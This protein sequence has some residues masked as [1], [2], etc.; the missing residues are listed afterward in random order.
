MKK[1]LSLTLSLVLTLSALLCGNAQADQENT[2]PTYQLPEAV[3][4]IRRALAEKEIFVSV[5]GKVN[6]DGVSIY[7]RETGEVLKEE[8]LL[9]DGE[10]VVDEEDLDDLVGMATLD[11][12]CNDV[13]LAEANEF[14]EERLMGLGVDEV[15]SSFSKEGDYAYF[16]FVL[17]GENRGELLRTFIEV[18][19]SAEMGYNTTFAELQEL[20]DWVEANF[21]W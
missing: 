1:F 5:Y 18:E 12:W 11:W 7:V 3:E 2:I 14:L 10:Y 21:D 20:C 17:L 6:A 9:V 4:Y 13:K 19:E 16:N 8:A 15:F